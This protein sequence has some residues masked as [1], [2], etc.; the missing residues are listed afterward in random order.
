[1]DYKEASSLFTLS[2]ITQHRKDHFEFDQVY[3]AET[4]GRVTSQVE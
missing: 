4:T 1:M 3:T 2:V